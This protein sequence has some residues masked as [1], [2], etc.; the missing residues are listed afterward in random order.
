MGKAKKFEL[1]SPTP[2]LDEEDEHTFA[3]IDEGIRGRESW[4]N[5]PRLKKFRKGL[6]QWIT[7]PLHAKG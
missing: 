6:P 2:M 1:E 3:A 4:T 5:R 7:A